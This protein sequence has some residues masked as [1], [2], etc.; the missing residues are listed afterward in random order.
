MLNV[1]DYL[2]NNKRTETSDILQRIINE[3]PNRTIYFP[4][5]EYIIDKP[6][7]TPAEPEKSVSLVLA[8]YA[9]I[10]AGENWTGDE[11]MIRLGGIYPANNIYT[12]GSNY[13]L[14]GGIIDGGG[15][16]NGISIDSG[17]ETFIRNTSIKNTK[18]G[19]IIKRGAN[20]GSSDCDIFGV[21]I[22]GTGEKESRGMYICGND[23][24]FTNMRMAKVFVG[25]E[26]CS[27]GNMLRNIHP[28]Y[29]YGNEEADKAY[30]ESVAFLD[31]CGD[32]NYDYCYSDQH[33]TG[34]YIKGRGISIFDNCYSCFY[35][36]KGTLHRGFAS[37]GE[38]NC[39][40]SNY[41]AGFPKNAVLLSEGKSGGQGVFSDIYTREDFIADDTYKK[42]LRGKAV[43]PY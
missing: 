42:Y 22:V 39:I 3:N 11:A 4:D 16:A 5:G 33:A 40:V 36:D 10:K 23:N 8:N 14:E 15:K 21:N 38:F 25:V 27:G 28:L 31:N 13:G 30:E 24:T 43:F 19:I 17:R 7:M 12:C 34:F 6:I 1:T 35:S 29:I 26:L 2:K 9:V 20:G 32:N 41:K 18:I 37:D